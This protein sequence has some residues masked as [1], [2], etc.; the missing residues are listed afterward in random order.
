[1]KNPFIKLFSVILMLNYLNTSILQSS[2]KRERHEPR[3]DNI[4]DLIDGTEIKGS[5]FFGLSSR[6]E[7]NSRH[8][9]NNTA[10]ESQAGSVSD[11]RRGGF[12]R[13]G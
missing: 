5:F 3:S 7:Q 12:G 10:G 4:F 11:F 6:K 9:G 8:R 1:M 13:M 2:S